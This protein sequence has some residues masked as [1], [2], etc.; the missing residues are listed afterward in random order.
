MS[1]TG[2][3]GAGPKLAEDAATAVGVE[4]EGCCRRFEVMA[5]SP[6]SSLLA[7]GCDSKIVRG[8]LAMR[9]CV[10]DAGMA[11]MRRRLLAA[12]RP[13]LLPPLI[14][15]RLETLICFGGIPIIIP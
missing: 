15:L 2:S 3:L 1:P 10:C 4:E 9:Y 12:G 13:R 14:Y 6:S 5:V 11:L 8:G 7:T